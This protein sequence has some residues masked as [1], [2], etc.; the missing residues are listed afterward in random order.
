MTTASLAERTD[1]VAEAPFETEGAD[2]AAI[3]AS[4]GRGDARGAIARCARA[5]GAALGR[6]CAAL[7]GN[8]GEAD[9]AVQETL[10]AAFDGAAQFRG[11]APVRGWLFGIARRM[12][13]R[14]LE[15]RTRQARRRVLLVGA[16]EAGRPVDEALDEARRGHAVRAA[17]DELRPTEREALLLRYEAELSYREVAEATGIDEA[18]ARQRVSRALARIRAKVEEKGSTR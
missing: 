6:F 5:Y 3:R 16:G 18:A 15:V 9:E 8:P 1:R 4:L 11:D 13:A 12:C 17:L 7:V 10:L 14:R 2:E